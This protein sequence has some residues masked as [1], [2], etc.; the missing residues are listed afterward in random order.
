LL[1]ALWSPKGGSGT[2]VVSAALGSFLARRRPAVLVDL[3]GDLPA[4]A[5]L[6]PYGPSPQGPLPYPTLLHWLAAGPTAPSDVLEELVC[7]LDDR[8]GL[9]PLGERLPVGP[10]LRPECGAALAAALAGGPDVVADAGRADHG[11]Q[12]AFVEVADA[13]VI[14]LRACYLALRRAVGDELTARAAG[15]VLVAEPGRSL[16]SR[17]V[18]DVLGCPVLAT[19]R[20]DP[21]VA[22]AVDAGL[23]I[24]RPPPVLAR[25][26]RSLAGA[27]DARRRR[28][29]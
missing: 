14:V 24:S 28:A 15:A 20:F 5:G 23:L 9:L 17:D 21:S 10:E 11:V 13:S 16:N 8:L 22:R 6:S 18:A 12:R 29:A 25:P 2:S 7:P 1:F 26:L 3:A 4:I 19:I 27:L